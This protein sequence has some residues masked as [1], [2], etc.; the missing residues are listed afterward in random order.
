MIKVLTI[1]EKPRI[2]WCKGLESGLRQVNR[3][4]IVTGRAGVL[5]LD[6]DGFAL[7]GNPDHLA[8]VLGLGTGVTVGTRVEGSD[9]VVVTVLFATGTIVTILSVVGSTETGVRKWSAADTKHA[10]TVHRCES[11]MIGE[12]GKARVAGR[13]LRETDLRET[14]LR[15]WGWEFES[16]WGSQKGWWWECEYKKEQG[17]TQDH[18]HNPHRHLRRRRPHNHHLRQEQ[19]WAWGP[20]KRR[21]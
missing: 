21:V 5:D 14:A 7:P 20:G 4:S 18:L 15:D 1:S 10:L 8:A 19:K 9:E 11:R 16:V 17:K 12:S 13:T 3:G 6:V 2:E